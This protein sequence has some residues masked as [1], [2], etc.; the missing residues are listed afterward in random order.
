MVDN[1]QDRPTIRAEQPEPGQWDQA[2]PPEPFEQTRRMGE[3]GAPLPFPQSGRGS[4]ETVI[5]GGPE[6]TFAWLAVKN[7]PRAGQLQRIYPDGL[8]I[9]RDARSDMVVDDEA[10]SR[11]HAKVRIEKEGDEERF[12]V[13]DLASGNGTFVNDE[14]VLKQELQDGDEIQVGNTTLVFKRI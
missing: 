4:D 8:L 7:G 14:E 9:G 11:Q 12:Y 1:D 6:P 3:P 5:L 10:V 13:Q 2:P